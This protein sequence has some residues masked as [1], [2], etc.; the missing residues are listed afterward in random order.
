MARTTVKQL[1]LVEALSTSIERNIRFGG[2]LFEFLHRAASGHRSGE[3]GRRSDSD[4][5]TVQPGRQGPASPT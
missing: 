4:C 1:S 3:H 5:P 2:L